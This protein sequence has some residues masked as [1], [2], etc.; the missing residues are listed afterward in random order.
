M[1]NLA[2]WVKK[3]MEEHWVLDTQTFVG[4]NPTEATKNS[5]VGKKA[6]GRALGLKIPDL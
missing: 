2:S 3:R 1:S 6:K 4:S 5:L